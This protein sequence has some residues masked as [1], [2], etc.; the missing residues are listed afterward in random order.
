[1]FE[2]SAMPRTAAAMI[3]AL[4]CAATLVSV[5]VA[6]GRP[7]AE[8]PSPDAQEYADSA[9]SL[10]QDRGFFTFIYDG[11]REPPRYPPGY[12]LALAPFALIGSFP[13]NVERGARAYVLLYVLAVVIAAW[14]LGG[15]VAAA[16]A[17]VVVGISPFA[18]DAAHLVMSDVLYAALTVAVLPLIYPRPTRSGNRAA[19]ALA[20]LAILVRLSGFVNFLALA[21]ATRKSG[22]KDLALMGIPALFGLAFLQW[23][24]YGSPFRTGYSYWGVDS[25]NFALSYATSD[26]IRHEGPFIF[27][28]RLGGHLLAWI[29]CPCPVGGAQAGLSN[30]VFYPALLAGL[31][32]VFSPPIV[33]LLG[34]L[35]AWRRRREAVGRYAL[36]L[37][38]ASLAFYLPYLFQGTRFMAGV[39]AVLTVLG[40]VWLAQ[41]G[42]TRWQRLSGS[43]RTDRAQ[44]GA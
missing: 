15:P 22:V 25:H 23:K 36:V 31:F 1:M 8:Q 11:Q 9:R 5:A 42:S 7:L 16:I 44:A 24:I 43:A 35:Y 41:F 40:S 18:R 10:A 39:G 13:G 6:P 12:P 17:A 3:A 37:V 32:W 30:I 19:A 2:L 20:G 14:V 34:L 27:P 28:D 26:V 21:A 29:A 4:V 38:V 33:P